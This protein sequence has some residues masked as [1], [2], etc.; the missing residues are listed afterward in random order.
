MTKKESLYLIMPN[1]FQKREYL[2]NLFE[3]NWSENYNTKR[4]D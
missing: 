4:L 2:A 3:E 1:R